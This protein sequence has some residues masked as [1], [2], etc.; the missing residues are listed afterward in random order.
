MDNNGGHRWFFFGGREVHTSC[1]RFFLW[2]DT[3]VWGATSS[4]SPFTS[5]DVRL[6]A[7]SQSRYTSQHRPLFSFLLFVRPLSTQQL[8][9]WPHPT[10]STSLSDRVRGFSV[11]IK[12][13]ELVALKPSGEKRS[14]R[15]VPTLVHSW[16]SSEEW[17]AVTPGRT[18][19]A[20]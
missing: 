5:N 14:S 12:L 1:P 15:Q 11:K 8:V 6:R 18:S 17:R 10:S 20:L 3:T 13:E 9:S 7:H 16:R 19:F 2:L 4:T